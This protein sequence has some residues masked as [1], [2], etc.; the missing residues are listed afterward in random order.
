MVFVRT[1]G[2]L[3]EIVAMAIIVCN[4]ANFLFILLFIKFGTT[5]RNY[6]EFWQHCN[7]LSNN[8]D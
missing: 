4:D 8:N 5:F 6:F 2:K 3:N 7:H 1:K